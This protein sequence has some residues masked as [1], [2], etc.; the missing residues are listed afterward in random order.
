MTG[1]LENKVALVT[2]GSTG[3]GRAGALAFARAGTKVLVA[4]VN[5]EDGEETV[6][7]VKEAGGEAIFV[8][9]DVSKAAEVQAMV[10]KAVETY[11][12]LD[13]A[14]NNAGI[15]PVDSLMADC[16]EEEW[17]L[18]IN[19][20]LK[21]MWLCM[22]YEIPQMIKQGKGA[23]VNTA[24]ML[25]FLTVERRSLYTASKH[26]V[27][28]LTKSAAVEYAPSSIRVN[29]VCPSFAL[30]PMLRNSMSRNPALRERI[31]GIPMGRGSTPEEIANV[32]VWLCTDEAS[33][34]TGHPMVVDGGFTIK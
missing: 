23:I 25:G 18:I 9:T 34:V 10:N 19:T 15:A 11:G 29:A 16:T 27:L 14:F 33:F 8:K 30:T 28:G 12:R 26:G 21:S 4:D 1:K 3:I 32:A 20:N 31:S 5:V 22:K 13:C 17:D 2:G 7:M 24:S 6:K